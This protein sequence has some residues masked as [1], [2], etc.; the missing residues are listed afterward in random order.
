MRFVAPGGLRVADRMTPARAPGRAPGADRAGGA[1]R[2]MAERKI[3]K[4]PLVDAEGAARPDHRARP[5]AAAAAAVCH[6]RRA[7]PPARRRRHRRDR[8][9]PRARAELIRAGADVLV[10]DIAHGHS[11]VMERALAAFRKRFGDFELIA[12]NV[13]TPRGRGSSSSAAS[14]ASRW[15]SAPAAAAR[16]ASPPASAC[17]RCRRSSNAARR[18]SGSDVALIADGG[19]KRTAPLFQALLFGGDTVMLGSAFAGTEEAPGEIVQKSVMLPESQKTVKVPF[20]VLRGMASLRRS[21]IGSTSRTPT[22]ELEAIGAEGM[23]ISVPAR[24][25]ARTIVRDMIKHLCSSVSYGGGLA[26]RAWKAELPDQAVRVGEARVL[27]AV[28][29]SSSSGLSMNS[30]PPGTPRHR[31]GSRP[32]GRCP[33]RRDGR[34]RGRW[35]SRRPAPSYAGFADEVE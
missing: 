15:A 2:L 12:G 6:A 23:E 13:A 32:S 4:L 27:E 19:V 21:A 5:R 30:S 29:S 22:V 7:R 35:G 9:L 25:S 3:K 28:S 24:G 33:C 14:T 16:R 34:F 1:E 20:K 10:I 11:V 31:S 26:A 17:R 18:W 8:R